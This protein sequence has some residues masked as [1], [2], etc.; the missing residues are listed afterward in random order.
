VQISKGAVR[1]WRPSRVARVRRACAAPLYG[2]ALVVVLVSTG[3]AGQLRS[4]ND[5]VYSEVQA[6]R[7]QGVYET[8]CASCHGA[9]LEGRVGP[10]LVG[11]DF[12]GVWGARP[13]VELVDK[14]HTTMP[15]Q[16]SEPL[17]RMESLEL[18]AYLLQAGQF[19][20]GQAEL[21]EATLTDVTLPEAEGV[22]APAS[23]AVE[24]SAPAA[25][26]AQLMR[27]IAFPNSNIIFN[28]QIKDPGNQPKAEP[29]AAS[30]DYVDWG[31]SFYSG[32]EA[33]DLAALALVD[34]ARLFLVPGRR[35]ENG[36]PVPVGRADWQQYTQDL[37]DVGRAAY[38]AS[39]SRSVDAVIGVVDRL[40]EACANCHKVYRDGSS[41][42]GGTGAD[43]CRLD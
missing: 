17:S 22:A 28:V 37:E 20:S 41:E 32:W 2:V 43:R 4:V 21:G 30:F 35:C 9:A 18:T 27:A 39:Q 10:P 33:V 14:I 23:G 40:D 34:S 19:P 7:G 38:Q 42:G 25:N 13:L 15:L 12:L 8:A 5:G 29:G 31:T 26:L 36:R 11:D 3:H 1:G 24:F 6:G 16:A